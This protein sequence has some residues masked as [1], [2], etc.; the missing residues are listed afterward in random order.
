MANDIRGA[1]ALLAVL[2]LVPAAGAT[3]ELWRSR[4][5]DDPRWASPGFDDSAWRAVP[6]PATWREQGYTGVDG[7][8]WFRRVA[9]LDAAARLAAARGQLAIRLGRS[10]VYGAYQVYAGGRLAG[11]SEGW[12][13]EIPFTRTEVFPVPRDAVGPDGRLALALRVRRVAWAADASPQAAPVGQILELGSY[14]ALKDGAEL[15]WD[16]TLLADLPGLLLAL[17]FC[18]VAPYHALLYLRR[19]REIGHLWFG[20]LA[21]GFAANTFA[22]SYWIYQLTSRHDLA[23]RASDLTGHLA[24]LLAIQ[25]LWTFFSRPISRLL[26]A[27]QL[28]HAA[29]AL[30]VGL[31]P[32][33]RLVIASEG[34]RTLWLL[35]LLVAAVVLIIREAWRGDAEARL[36]ALSGLA[37]V[38]AEAV[39]L[40]G[41]AL[42]L[43]WQSP[44]PLPP[45][46]FAAVLAAMS[47]SL[48]NR[49]RRVHDELD[50]L[51]VSLEEQVR[52]RTAALQQAREGAL[53]ASRAKSEFLANMSHEIRT[54]MSGVIGMTSLLLDTRLT[55]TQRDYVETIRASGEALLVLI[56]DI[57]DLSKME[58]GKVKIER[59]PFDLAAVIA[60]SLEMV[61]PLA[62]RQGLAL[63]HTI[64]PG[65]PQALVGDLARTRQ[66]L[67]NLVG[68]A[69]KFT[70]QGEVRVSLSARPLEDGRWEALFAVADTGIGIPG[71]ELDRLFVDFHQLDG[72]LTRKHGGTGL[73]LA[74]SRR[75]TELMGGRIW[76][77]STVGHGSTFYFT[78]V[79]EAAACP[80]RQ[81]AVPLA[82]GRGPARR[83][84]ADDR[85]RILLAE[86]HPVN[87]QVMLGLLEHLGYRADLAA[88]GLEVLAAL[89]R[90][91]YDVILMDVQMPEM[92]GL[93]ATRR[94][95]R[96][97][98]GGCR[99]RILAMTAH[100][101]SGDRE[102]CL[103]VGMDGYLSKP[104]QIADLA[105]ALAAAE[106]RDAPL[107]PDPLDRPTL[108]LLC[109]LSA[110]GEDVLGTL[111]RTFA[112][113]AAGDL[114]EIRRLA[115]EDQWCE[116]ERAAHRLKGGSGC[117]G[118]VR[119]AALCAAVEERVRALR[120]GEV[121]PL[122]TELERE[123]ERAHGALDQAVRENA[124]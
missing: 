117:L 12:T 23:L 13:L 32:D 1:T 50:R 37:L 102:R 43:P 82:A 92:D 7:R 56:N 97:P 107:P 30:F 100:A 65:T 75:L 86:D 16:R 87:R 122:L 69:V 85:L 24:A 9:P 123:L 110:N 81:P 18:V 119:V 46:G 25:F 29:L 89:D 26:R 120:T 71:E 109:E 40:A 34:V 57:L 113:S 88:N 124:R 21:L 38:A 101:M 114:A 14:Q 95:R 36:L 106:P 64:A 2:L 51:H 27:Y 17:L 66:I 91:P 68:N 8:I 78:L 118:A 52:E 59:A 104:V 33:P 99:P 94:I 72:S 74:I 22:S 83:P 44:V 53:A 39:E 70:P 73:G 62:A 67:L 105:A 77:E 108:D 42:N 84:H 48:S 111:V 20:L 11:S 103:E 61:A 93:E 45:F 35:P 6:L 121:G 41:Q 47:Y 15:A 115:A 49:F 10:T 80:P 5:G 54:P 31:W 55:A 4:P 19:R 96:Q 76:A 3:A 60:E 28:S 90:Q 116:V 79:G 58:S 63:H 98:P 112:A